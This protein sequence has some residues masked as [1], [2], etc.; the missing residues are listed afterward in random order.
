MPIMCFPDGREVTRDKQSCAG[1]KSLVCT[2][3]HSSAPTSPLL[4]H[5]PH[6]HQHELALSS[7]SPGWSQCRELL[8]ADPHS[9]VRRQAAFLLSGP[10]KDHT[11]TYLSMGSRPLKLWVDTQD[12]DLVLTENPGEMRSVKQHTEQ[13]ARS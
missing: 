6:H 3:G 4:S 11:L 2:G 9:Q 10:R 8:T 7:P 1:E 5:N 12:Q 13:M